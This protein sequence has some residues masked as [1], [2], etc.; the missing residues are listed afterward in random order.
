VIDKPNSFAGGC[1]RFA[2]AALIVLLIATIL[3]G[4]GLVAWSGV[5]MDSR[6]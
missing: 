4:T 2:V 6:K 5:S 1:E 3:C